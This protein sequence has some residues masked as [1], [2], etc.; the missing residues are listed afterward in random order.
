MMDLGGGPRDSGT[1][2]PS[3]QTYVFQLSPK[4]LATTGSHALTQYEVFNI[5]F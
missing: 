1:S 5:N 3:D 4:I 2:F